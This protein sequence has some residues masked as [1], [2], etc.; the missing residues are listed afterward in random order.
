MT[1]ALWFFVKNTRLPLKR[2]CVFGTKPGECACVAG[3]YRGSWASFKWSVLD[4]TEESSCGTQH[5]L[6]LPCFSALWPYSGLEVW[7]MV[8]RSEYFRNSLALIPGS[9]RKQRVPRDIGKR[10]RAACHQHLEDFSPSRGDSELLMR[11][12]FHKLL[13]SFTIVQPGW[14]FCSQH[15]WSCFKKKLVIES[16]FFCPLLPRLTLVSSAEPVHTALSGMKL[17][18]IMKWR[19]TAYTFLGKTVEEI[20]EQLLFSSKAFLEQSVIPNFPCYILLPSM[21]QTMH[22]YEWRTTNSMSPKCFGRHCSMKVRLLRSHL[23]LN[24]K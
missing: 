3:E 13:S 14:I 5:G 6:N 4:I 10:K 12:D 24:T 20:G 1:P 17:Q 21:V 2:H 16:L 7:Q 22:R 15:F 18:F 11:A 9:N 8:C 19:T 23:M